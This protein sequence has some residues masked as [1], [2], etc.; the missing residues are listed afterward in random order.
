M[1]VDFFVSRERETKSQHPYGI[2]DSLEVLQ[3]HEILA[4]FKVLR[5][6]VSRPRLESYT[7]HKGHREDWP[8]RRTA[9]PRFTA[10]LGGGGKTTW[11]RHGAVLDAVAGH[12]VA[13]WRAV[14]ERADALHGVRASQCTNEPLVGQLADRGV[15]IRALQSASRQGRPPSSG[16]KVA[17]CVSSVCAPQHPPLPF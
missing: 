13:D 6:K 16:A 4:C 14:H 5:R 12:A 10:V 17:A 3:N 11:S 9:P 1:D 15:C 2:Y 8:R 7:P